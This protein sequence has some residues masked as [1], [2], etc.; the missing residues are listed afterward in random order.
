M[1]NLL[2]TFALLL[3]FGLSYGQIKVTAPDG[4]TVIGNEPA[5]S[6]GE[7]NLKS[8]GEAELEFAVDAGVG[9]PDFSYQVL[10]ETKGNIAYNTSANIS[11]FEILADNNSTTTAGLPGN[12]RKMVI[13]GDAGGFVGIGINNPSSKLHVNGT[14]TSNGGTLF[15]GGSTS[16]KKGGDFEYG[17]ETILGM[18]LA[19]FENTGKV[20]RGAD[21]FYSVNAKELQNV[22]P[23]FVTTATHVDY[24]DTDLEG[25]STK[26]AEEDFYY[27]NSTLIQ[28]TLINAMQEQQAQIEAKD[29]KI[30]DLEDRL[31]RIEAMLAQGANTVTAVEVKDAALGQNA[32]NPF[33]ERTAINYAVPTK[34]NSAVVEIYNLNGSL[35]KSVN[36]AKG[37]GTL[38]LNAGE[39]AAGTYTYRLVIDGQ[40]VDTK[41]MLLTK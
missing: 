39:L 37:N 9:K 6:P 20:K 8:Y 16:A 34:A 2:L 24:E 29:A 40:I 32:P 36:V 25:G 41:K 10:G 1:R 21:K 35:L 11:G 5:S 28:L 30:S 19:S 23:E 15:T 22:A 33:N 12:T 3:T 18:Q 4:D 7:A 14:I 17:L 31:A 27:V 26:I 38:E 13:K